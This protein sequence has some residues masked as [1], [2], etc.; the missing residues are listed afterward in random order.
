MPTKMSIFQTRK[1]NL[2]TQKCNLQT[3]NVILLSQIFL[4]KKVI[5]NRKRIMKLTKI[6][7][8]HT[9]FTPCPDYDVIAWSRDIIK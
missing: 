1:C 9:Y 5:Q 6:E 3:K 4:H 2:Q 7:V 8:F